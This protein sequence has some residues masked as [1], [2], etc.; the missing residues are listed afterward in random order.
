[1][2]AEQSA[3]DVLDANSVR[4]DFP[5]LLEAALNGPSGAAD[6][7]GAPEVVTPTAAR[8]RSHDIRLDQNQ[9]VSTGARDPQGVRV[10]PILAVLA[11]LFGLAWIVMNGLA[12]P[13]GLAWVRAFGGYHFVNPSATPSD[14]NTSPPVSNAD[15]KDL[16][17]IHDAT[18]RGAERAT[19]VKMPDDPSLFSSTTITRWKPGAS[20]P[21]APSAS[22]HP[23]AA[24]QRPTSTGAGAAKPRTEARLVPVPETRPTTIEGW[25]LHDVVDGTAVLQGPG[26]TF[27]V[28]RGDPVPGLGKVVAIFRWGNRLMVATSRGLISKP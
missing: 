7:E 27:R 14:L 3:N 5:A 18:V 17:P 19:A 26:G 2:L 28:K 21:P 15:R 11:A 12:S 25:T 1:M 20:V 9:R 22:K 23:P 10:W 8:R 4:V 16:L 24:Q 6:R 13:F